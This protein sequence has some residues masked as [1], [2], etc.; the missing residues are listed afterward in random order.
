MKDSRIVECLLLAWYNDLRD[1]RH[2]RWF[3]TVLFTTPM[4][5]S[6]LL[7]CPFT[8]HPALCPSLSP[9]ALP[10]IYIPHYTRSFHLLSLTSSLPPCCCLRSLLLAYLHPHW[11]ASLLWVRGQCGGSSPSHENATACPMLLLGEGGI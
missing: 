1:S 9:T 2:F 11:P 3:W 4:Y 7:T 5:L 8:V 6:H 10:L